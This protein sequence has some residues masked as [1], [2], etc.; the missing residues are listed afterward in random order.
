MLRYDEFKETV[1]KRIKDY[2]PTKYKDYS[3]EI[4]ISAIR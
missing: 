4:Y 3:I 2:L 1:I